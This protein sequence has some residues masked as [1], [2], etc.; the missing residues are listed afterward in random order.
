MARRGSP[1]HSVLVDPDVLA[2]GIEAHLRLG[3]GPSIIAAWAHEQYLGG[4]D[5]DR[6]VY[7]ALMTLIAMD[8]GPQFILDASALGELAAALRG[9]ASD[10]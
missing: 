2:D 3:S 1:L 10:R 6:V 7:T 4:R 8:E 5:H 9:S